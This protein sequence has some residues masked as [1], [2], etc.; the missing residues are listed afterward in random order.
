MKLN[1]RTIKIKDGSGEER[2]RA[3]PLRAAVV[4]VV[5]VERKNF[6]VQP[7]VCMQQLHARFSLA[8][9]HIHTHPCTHTHSLS[10]SL[11]PPHT[12]MLPRVQLR[13]VSGAA[14]PADESRYS[15]PFPYLPRCSP[16]SPP[17]PPSWWWSNIAR[18]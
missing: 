4:V 3:G 17:S 1:K 16:S 15:F 6:S 11:S 14:A 12:R 7:R 8:R 2:R 5:V 13:S 18:G 9:S 10:L